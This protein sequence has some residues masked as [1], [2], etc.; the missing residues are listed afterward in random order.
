MHDGIT[1]ERNGVP[2]AVICTEPFISSGKAM[3]KIGGIPDYPFVVVP[4]PLG[5]LS[6]DQLRERAMQA[7]PEVLK[8]LLAR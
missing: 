7:A 4:H 3:S 2:T 1:L 5:S 8:I 6:I